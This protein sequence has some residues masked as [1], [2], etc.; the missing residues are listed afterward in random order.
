MVAVKVLP[1]TRV[2]GL[3]VVGPTDRLE[4]PLLRLFDWVDS[5]GYEVLG[6]PMGIF[7]DDPTQVPPEHCRSDLCV[8]VGPE[9][10]SDG[11]WEVTVL[12]SETV[13]VAE[14]RGPYGDYTG[15]YR[16]VYEWIQSHGYRAVGPPAE[17]YLSDP[18]RT[19]PDALRTE[20][21][22]PIDRAT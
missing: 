20:I 7:Y 15:T 1:T 8:P 12:P 4:A 17:V 18:D 10:E 19:S 6:P 16:L 2:A 14:H 11:E 21:R 13:A 22:V 9:A 3:R 5:R